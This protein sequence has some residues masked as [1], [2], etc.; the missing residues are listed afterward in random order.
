M[1]DVMSLTGLRL[2]LSTV[3]GLPLGGGTSEASPPLLHV[4]VLDG[5]DSQYPG[6]QVGPTQDEDEEAAAVLPDEDT[7]AFRN[8][9]IGMLTSGGVRK[10]PT[11]D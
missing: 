5:T 9:S 1:E 8:S 7:E 10:S 6:M 11:H 4:Q 2:C 3:E